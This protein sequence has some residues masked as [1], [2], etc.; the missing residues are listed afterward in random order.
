MSF[1]VSLDGALDEDGHL[2]MGFQRADITATI[3]YDCASTQK[4]VTFTKD[5]MT[6]T[7]EV[8]NGIEMMNTIYKKSVTCNECTTNAKRGGIDGQ[9]KQNN[10]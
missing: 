3:Y 8:P 2:T 1:M 4:S 6:Q 5:S 10:Q 7:L 9:K